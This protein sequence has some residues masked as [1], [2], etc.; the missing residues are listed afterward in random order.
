MERC[1]FPKTIFFLLTLYLIISKVS[2]ATQESHNYNDNTNNPNIRH[3]PTCNAAFDSHL[4][5]QNALPD[6]SFEDKVSQLIEDL[7][8]FYKRLM[9]YEQYPLSEEVKTIFIRLSNIQY[10]L[11]SEVHDQNTLIELESRI[12]ECEDYIATVKENWTAKFQD[13]VTL[14]ANFKPH[15]NEQIEKLK[16]ENEIAFS[17]LKASIDDCVNEITAYRFDSAEKKLQKIN[18]D[19]RFK[20]VVENI[21]NLGEENFYV[22]LNFADS[23]RN[24]PKNAV[25]LY[26]ALHDE[27]NL[28]GHESL[29]KLLLIIRR[30]KPQIS[31]HLRNRSNLEDRDE[32]ATLTKHVELFLDILKNSTRTAAINEIADAFILNYLPKIEP[33]IFELAQTGFFDMNLIIEAAVDRISRKLATKHLSTVIRSNTGLCINETTPTPLTFRLTRI[34]SWSKYCTLSQDIKKLAQRTINSSPVSIGLGPIEYC[35]KVCIVNVNFKEYL[36]DPDESECSNKRTNISCPA[37]TTDEQTIGKPNQLAWNLK[38]IGNNKYRI[39]SYNNNYTLVVDDRKWDDERRSVSTR[40][41]SE[42]SDK[43]AWQFESDG[44]FVFIKNIH[45]QEYLTASV[46]GYINN[47]TTIDLTSKVTTSKR[48]RKV[49]TFVSKKLTPDCYWTIGNCP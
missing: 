49:F 44:D 31:Q 46:K 30:L 26:E 47:V 7:D 37:Y 21:Y 24:D 33:R 27:M 38:T 3:R 25:I 16:R 48:L 35:D 8:Q 19:Q 17:S 40:Q 34:L 2:N 20:L 5:I 41:I 4:W 13:I 43:H 32:N 28:A 22:L 29:S 42:D 1:Q 45:H 18:H 23:F 14:L 15:M 36:Y 6:Q 11:L 39:I 9:N 12:E 10:Y